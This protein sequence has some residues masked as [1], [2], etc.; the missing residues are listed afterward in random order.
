MRARARAFNPICDNYL[1]NAKRS[2]R[3]GTCAIGNRR[4]TCFSMQPDASRCL[5]ALEGIS[6]VCETGD[7][8]GSN[9]VSLELMNRLIL[10]AS[11]GTPRLRKL[12]GV[13]RLSVV[14]PICQLL[15]GIV[16]PPRDFAKCRVFVKIYLALSDFANSAGAGNGRA[17]CKIRDLTIS[18]L[19]NVSCRSA[20]Y[21]ITWIDRKSLIVITCI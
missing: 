6:Q 11:R 13:T 1:I 18:C 15:A 20:K 16:N 14:L 12:R 21:F 2:P 5:S 9:I 8:V 19:K 10:L 7:K 4:E 3:S 17:D